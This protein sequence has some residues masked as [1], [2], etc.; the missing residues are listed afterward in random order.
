MFVKQL[1]N[2][3]FDFFLEFKNNNIELIIHSFLRLIIKFFK[4]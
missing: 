2:H 3:L 1:V 4:V